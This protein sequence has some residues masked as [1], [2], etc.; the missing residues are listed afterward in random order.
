MDCPSILLLIASVVT[1]QPLWLLRWAVLFS[2][3]PQSLSEILSEILSDRPVAHPE[4]PAS[5]GIPLPGAKTY[6]GSFPPSWL[7][8]GLRGLSEVSR[9]WTRCLVTRVGSVVGLRISS[10]GVTSSGWTRRSPRDPEIFSPHGSDDWPGQRIRVG[11]RCRPR[12][13]GEVRRSKAGRPLRE[14]SAP[15]KMSASPHHGV[16]E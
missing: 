8:G 6:A 14:A 15:R 10:S 9:G 2:Q 11:A 13:E 12:Q 1:Y 7:L 4:F 3:R 16:Q 5:S